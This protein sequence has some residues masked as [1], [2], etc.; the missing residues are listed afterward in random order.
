MAIRNLRYDTDPILRK[1]SREVEV[2]DD[3]IRKIVE[4]M[5]D[6]MYKYDGVGLSAP[7][8]G[9]LRR[10]IV[11]DTYEEGE[12]LAI[13]NP[14]IVKVEGKKE[15]LEGCLSFPDV[16]GKV[17][18][19]YK[20]VI[21]GLDENG[22]KIEIHAE[23]ILAEAILHEIDHLNGILFVDMVKKG[24]LVKELSD[25]TNQKLDD[26]TYSNI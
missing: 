10:I 15:Y 5:F 8:I 23:D 24:T 21:K 11:I 2:V 4:D 20:A 7:Q 18:R 26:N 1:K 16:Y 12:K 22:K 6:T 14:E 13:I 17:D 9:I 25:G 3:R 19:P